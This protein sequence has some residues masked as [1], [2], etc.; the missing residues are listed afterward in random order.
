MRR[1]RFVYG[2][3]YLAR[4]DK[5]PIDPLELKLGSTTYQQRICL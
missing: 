2:K 1:C 5:A 3:S 4:V